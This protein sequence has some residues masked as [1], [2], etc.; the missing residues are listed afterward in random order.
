MLTKGTSVQ[1]WRWLVFWLVC[2]ED[3]RNSAAS[4]AFAIVALETNIASRVSGNQ[5]RLKR[6]EQAG[7]NTFLTLIPW[8]YSFYSPHKTGVDK[9]LSKSHSVRQIQKNSNDWVPNFPTLALQNWMK[10][11]SWDLRY[12]KYFLECFIDTEGAALESLKCVRSKFVGRKKSPDFSDGI[13]TLQ[14]SNKEIGCCMSLNV[15]FL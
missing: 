11:Y 15:H 12:L 3:L 7:C 5:G 14:N 6:L 1:V 2:K 9:V 10:A 8:R 13:Q 4:Y